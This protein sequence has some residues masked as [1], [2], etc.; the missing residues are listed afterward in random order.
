MHLMMLRKKLY[1][2]FLTPFEKLSV[3]LKNRPIDKEHLNFDYVKV[4]LKS[5]VNRVLKPK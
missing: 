4:R 3:N 1:C 2:S 5:L